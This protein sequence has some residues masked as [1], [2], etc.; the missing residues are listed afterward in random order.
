M[1]TNIQLQVQTKAT[2]EYEQKVVG[3][4]N[5]LSVLTAKN[6]ATAGVIQAEAQR[7]V[8]NQLGALSCH[9]KLIVACV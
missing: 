1:I 5:D 9:S 4:L 8:D 6:Q 7:K 3:V 2:K